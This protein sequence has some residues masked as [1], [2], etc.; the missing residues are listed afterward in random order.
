MYKIL[1]RKRG[2]IQ[3]CSAAE[4]KGGCRYEN[5]QK[6]H[7]RTGICGKADSRCVHA[8]DSGTDSRK[9]IFQKG[10]PSVLVI[11]RGAGGSCFCSDYAAGCCIGLQRGRAG[12]SVS[13][14]G[15]FAG[16]YEERISFGKYSS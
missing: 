1:W 13:G 9:C 15:S 16:P 8:A 3:R 4:R 5:V 2:R 6:S 11:Y 7:E 10:N 12:E 14:N